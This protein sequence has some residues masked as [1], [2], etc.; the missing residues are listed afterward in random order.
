ML[1]LNHKIKDSAK[2]LE[3]QDRYIDE[4]LG[5]LKQ[6]HLPKKIKTDT[7]YILDCKDFVMNE[8]TYD[9]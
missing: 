3:W 5:I 6:K 1:V 7:N 4:L 8:Q 9:N 2:R